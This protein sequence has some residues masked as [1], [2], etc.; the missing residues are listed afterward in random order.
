MRPGYAK[1]AMQIPGANS[2]LEYDYHVYFDQMLPSPNASG[3]V[4]SARH[5]SAEYLVR[6]LMVTRLHSAELT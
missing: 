3:R 1:A 5:S 6:Q 2:G 4:N